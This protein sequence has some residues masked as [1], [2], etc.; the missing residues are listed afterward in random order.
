MLRLSIVVAAYYLWNGTWHL[1]CC[2]GLNVEISCVLKFNFA[3][4]C[5]LAQKCSRPWLS[6]IPTLNDRLKPFISFFLWIPLSWYKFSGWDPDLHL[7]LVLKI[8][9]RQIVEILFQS[10]FNECFN[11]CLAPHPTYKHP[12]KNKKLKI[13]RCQFEGINKIVRTSLEN[14]YSKFQQCIESVK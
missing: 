6:C 1:V 11:S 3:L 10:Q 14:K 4:V 7:Y 12:E 2:L 9:G 8:Y 5:A 13:R